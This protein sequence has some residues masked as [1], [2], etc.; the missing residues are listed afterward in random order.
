M[1]EGPVPALPPFFVGSHCQAA[2]AAEPRRRTRRRPRAVS[3]SRCGVVSTGT[4]PRTQNGHIRNDTRDAS[5]RMVRSRI[6]SICRKNCVASERACT[7]VTPQNLHGKEGVDGS[8]PSEGSAKA[9]QIAGFF[10]RLELHELQYAVGMEPVWSLQVQKTAHNASHSNAKP[11]SRRGCV[12]AP[13]R[14]GA[15][16]RRAEPTSAS[17]P[18]P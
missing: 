12:R 3:G 14:L 9:A 11:A 18:H 17:Q 10:G 1:R 13:R 15:G 6:R 7:R 2:T 5:R 8:S 16:H 4:R